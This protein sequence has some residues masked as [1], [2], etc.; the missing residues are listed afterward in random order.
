MI[1]VNEVGEYAEEQGWLISSSARYLIQW[2]GGF[3]ASWYSLNPIGILASLI[4]M[5]LVLLQLFWAW[6]AL[7]AH[8]GAL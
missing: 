2:V 1:Q 3:V 7:M 5:I 4:I 6:A 8:N